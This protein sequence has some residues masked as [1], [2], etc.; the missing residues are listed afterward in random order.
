M[1]L[2]VR[3]VAAS[4]ALLWGGAILAVGVTNLMQPRYGKEFLRVVASIY[5]GYR[6]RPTIANVA[7]GTAY[8]A[9]DGAVGGALCAW[10]Y[11][12]CVTMIE[13]STAENRR[14]RSKCARFIHC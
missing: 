10:L 3:A 6:A 7:V 11:N 5:P 12:R 8:A 4:S 9:A 2:S 13:A 1:K 14:P